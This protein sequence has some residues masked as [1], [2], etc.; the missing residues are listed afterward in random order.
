MIKLFKISGDSL[1]PIYKNKDIVLSL[2]SKIIKLKINDIVV[3]K[4]KDYG[5][6]IKKIKE[7]SIINNQKSFYLVGTNATSIDSRNFGYIPEN[8]ITNKVLFKFF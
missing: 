7:I 8:N 3:F 5:L 6:M 4:H 1:Y 2:S